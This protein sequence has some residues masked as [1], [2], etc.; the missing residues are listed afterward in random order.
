MNQ[1]I[2]SNNNKTGFPDLNI[3]SS[4]RESFLFSSLVIFYLPGLVLYM[5]RKENFLSPC[6]AVDINLLLLSRSSL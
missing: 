2:S 3:L 6:Y 4:S 5:G 1:S